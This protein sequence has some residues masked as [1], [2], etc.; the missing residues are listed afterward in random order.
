M[1]KELL[2][3]KSFCKE[4]K[5]TL[6]DERILDII[7]FGSALRGKEG[8]RDI[9]LLVVYSKK[10]FEDLD[11]KIR[12]DLEK[13]D[14]RISITS[15]SYHELFS[16]NFSARG[17]VILEGYSL[18]NRMFVSE[19]FGYKSLKLFKYSL[20]GF[21]A[22]KRMQFYYAL[23]GRGKNKGLLKKNKLYKFSQEIIISEVESS[24]L[25]KEFFEKWK[26]DYEE[27]PI[28]LPERIFKYRI[29]KK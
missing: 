23:Y 4:I 19:G 13:I 14:K 7:I 5:K 2:N 21:N 9:D 24:E 1:L 10:I 27:F 18:K 17:A 8:A 25:I 20:K 12:K 11:Y 26:I 29:L 22:S 16:P 28:I 15:K 6:K 3:N